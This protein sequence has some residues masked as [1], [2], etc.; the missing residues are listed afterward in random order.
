MRHQRGQ[1]LPLAAFGILIAGAA[2]V[3]MF[4][5]GQKITEKSMIANAADASA[6]SAGVWTAR[7]LNYMA[8]TNR[9][10]VANHVAVGHYVSYISWFRYI[11]YSIDGLQD[12]TSWVPYW[13]TFITIAERIV[14]TVKRV[15]DQVAR[16]LVPAIDSLN[17]LYRLSQ[18][19]VAA[20]LVYGGTAG[21][22]RLMEATADTYDQAIT[23]NNTDDLNA[24]PGVFSAPLI[25]KVQ[26]QR[27]ELPRFVERYTAGR[28]S[29]RITQLITANIRSNEDNRRWIEGNRGWRF[30]LG[31]GQL[32]KHGSTQQSQ[33]QS[34][35]NW[36][37]SDRLEAC[38][39]AFGWNCSRITRNTTAR[40]TE[41]ARNYSG[42]PNY[43]NTRGAITRNP[44]LDI[45]AV[46]AKRQNTVRTKE[47]LGMTTPN[48]PM[49]VAALAKVEFS[50]PSEGIGFPTHGRNRTEYA[51]LF[52]PFWEAHLTD[53]PVPGI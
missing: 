37:A 8:Y 16:V 18:A 44:S 5:N 24:L 28:D 33:N 43:Y 19:E 30:T 50:R 6:Y 14:T 38:V 34:R 40:A 25:A 53:I 46:A 36:T 15:N 11:E 48:E 51:N 26:Y 17:G 49:M 29:G 1:I 42:V 23:V 13:G 12:Y 41:F 4:N 7:H 35:A 39:W 22:D 45:A 2:L 3:M 21:L 9:A 52:N 32:R 20:S 47:L 10:M 31:P 27:V